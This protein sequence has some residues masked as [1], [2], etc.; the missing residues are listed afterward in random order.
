M[1]QN[2]KL[3]SIT[4][5]L[6]LGMHVAL[7]A[8]TRLIEVTCERN[9]T[10]GYVFSC[11]KN[12]EGSYVVFIRINDAYNLNQTEFKEVVNGGGGYLFSVGLFE[13]NKSFGFS[14]YTTTYL[15]GVP[16][17]KID[18]SF[19][20]ALP[21]RKGSPV[22]V[23]NLHDL[24]EKYFAETP[25][26]KMKAFEFSSL[27]RDT[28]CAIR[29]GVVVSVNDKY[30]MDTTIGKSYTSNVN[31]ILIEQPDGTLASYSGFKKGS[32]FVKEG[33]T[34]FPFT[35]LGVLAH[36]DVSKKHQLRLSVT[37]LADTNNDHQNDNSDTKKNK[38][39]YEY[40]NPYFLTDKGTCHI[41]GGKKYTAEVSD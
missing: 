2:I 37:F 20:Y 40:I 1:N 16:N 33:Q 12:V 35:P 8:Q 39:Y 7:K 31:S 15:R 9:G 6:L 13:R 21:F 34:V 22:T 38:R 26:R 24:R 29:K 3:I 36:Y 14:S 27:D 10:K 41:Q 11:T 32:I 5:L 18:T 19:V 17:P 25:T 23:S 30:E 4:F 28:A